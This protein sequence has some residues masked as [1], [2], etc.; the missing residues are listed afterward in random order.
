MWTTDSNHGA[1]T[2]FHTGRHMLDPAQPTLGGWVHYGLGSINDDLPQFI[3]IGFRAFWNRKDGLYLGPSH[4]AEPLR[5]DPANPL[6][7]GRPERPAFCV[8]LRPSLEMCGTDRHQA[9]A[10]L[11]RIERLTAP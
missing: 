9:I 3:S 11:E 5:I 6:D 8:G 1:Q 10:W 7:F 4:D 2:Q